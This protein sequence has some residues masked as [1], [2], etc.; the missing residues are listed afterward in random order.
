MPFSFR[1]SDVFLMVRLGFW[2][3]GTKTMEVKCC[4]HSIR[5]RVSGSYMTCSWEPEHP[6]EGCRSG[7]PCKGTAPA[8]GT[9]WE[10]SL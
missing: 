4:S 10:A 1:S 7:C 2:V 5:S 9:L 6:A 8:H 3:L